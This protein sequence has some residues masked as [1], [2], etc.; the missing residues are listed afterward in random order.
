M[1]LLKVEMYNSFKNATIIE[2]HW[3]EKGG[4]NVLE[5]NPICFICGDL[6]SGGVLLKEI[7]GGWADEVICIDCLNEIKNRLDK[8]VVSG[9]P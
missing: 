5:S 7:D 1:I 6:K 9:E 2:D 8:I 4:W 3:R